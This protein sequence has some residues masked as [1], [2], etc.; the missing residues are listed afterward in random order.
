MRKSRLILAIISL[1]FITSAILTLRTV[2]NRSGQASHYAVDFLPIRQWGF[3]YTPIVLYVEEVHG[4][5]FS[6][7]NG[8]VLCLGGVK[9]TKFGN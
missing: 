7:P 3:G 1:V 8:Y 9:I 6:A 2:S 4:R 5:N